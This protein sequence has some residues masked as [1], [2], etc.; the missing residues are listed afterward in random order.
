[1]PLLYEERGHVAILTLSRPD[2]RNAWGV[3]FTEGLVTRLGAMAKDKNIRCVILTG[4]DAGK[5]FSAGAD[6]KRRGVHNAA[7]AGDFIENL[8]NGRNTAAGAVSEFPKPLIAAVNGYAIGVGCIVTLCADMVIAS[9]RAQW[10]LPQVRLGIMP[11]FGGSVR[12]ARIIGKNNAFRAA[13]GYPID[14]AEAY[15]I[16][17][18]QWLTPHEKMMEQALEVAENIASLPPLSVRIAKESLVRGQDIPNLADATFMDAYRVMAL[19]RT[20]DI[21]EAA[22]AARERRKGK[23]RAE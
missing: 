11:A 9:E 13:M 20:E 7:T 6:M 17:L 15:R 23:Y 21:K 14:G 19:Q 1:M 4:D 12:L 2:A 10:S 22:V 8:P 3:D 5:A 16:G 18:A